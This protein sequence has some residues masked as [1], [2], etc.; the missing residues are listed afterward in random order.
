MFAVKSFLFLFFIS[1]SKNTFYIVSKVSIY[2]IE[3]A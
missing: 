1:K 2:W 3:A